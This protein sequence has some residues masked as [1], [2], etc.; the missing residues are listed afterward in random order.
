[1]ANETLS[2]ELA[3]REIRYLFDR[4]MCEAN[5]G[6]MRMD[7]IANRTEELFFAIRYACSFGLI[8]QD[9]REAF[10]DALDILREEAY[11]N[12]VAR[13]RAQ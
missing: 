1:M 2:R 9:E 7:A 3:I 4:F 13:V 12:L 5:H 11:A 10:G 8:G 6:E